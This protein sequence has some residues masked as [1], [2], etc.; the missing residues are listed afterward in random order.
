MPSNLYKLR[1][2]LKDIEEVHKFIENVVN[3]FFVMS[4][5]VSLHNLL[6][7]YIYLLYRRLKWFVKQH[8]YT[9]QSDKELSTLLNG[10]I[11]KTSFW[12][13]ICGTKEPEVAH[14]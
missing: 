11:S 14:I 13:S 1:L 8:Q 12:L 6:D 10:K 3:I 9:K 2:I 5:S 7:L 4:L